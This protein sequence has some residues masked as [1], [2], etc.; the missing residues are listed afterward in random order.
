[1]ASFMR[2]SH[3][4]GRRIPSAPHLVSTQGAKQQSDTALRIVPDGLAAEGPRTPLV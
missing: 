2:S 1:L 4:N 3:L